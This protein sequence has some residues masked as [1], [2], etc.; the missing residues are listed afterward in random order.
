MV[1]WV[2][3]LIAA[4][5]LFVVEMFTF[6]FYLLWL[7]LGALVAGLVALLLPDALL[8]QVVAGSLVAL[9]L[10]VFTKPLAARLR[11]SRGF[12]DTGTDIV[13]RKG[14]VVE[15]I[16]PGRYGQV[17]VGGDTWSATSTVALGKDQEVIVVR[18]G[19]TI[20]EVERWGDMY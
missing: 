1:V 6:T 10:T 8:L 7:S 20:I 19:T 2:L 3:W 18:R 15:A 5:V 9:I 17:K 16:E 13:G 14:L 11:N 12:K 4:G